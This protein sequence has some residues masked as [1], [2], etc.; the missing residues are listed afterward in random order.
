VGRPQ[1]S[2]SRNSSHDEND[3]FRTKQDLSLRAA[4]RPQLENASIH[5]RRAPPVGC[6]VATLRTDWP[7]GHFN[8]QQKSDVTE[9]INLRAN[10]RD[11]GFKT[12]STFF[13]RVSLEPYIG[14]DQWRM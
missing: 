1:R 3:P 13:A 2:E 10:L 6:D 5:C 7:H 9:K 11:F 14:I 4:A 12:K 8:E